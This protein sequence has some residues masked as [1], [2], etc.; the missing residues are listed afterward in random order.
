[1]N[2]VFNPFSGTFGPVAVADS[3]A[4]AAASATAASNSAS[5]ASG[6]ASA[7]NQS[8]IEAVLITQRMPPNANF[9]AVYTLSAGSNTINLGTLALS[10]GIFPDESSPAN[11]MSL[12]IGS[13]SYNLGIL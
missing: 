3:T 13:T 7:A 12:A 2:Y 5:A 8:V 9:S 1:M 11:R 4:Q 10:G 6:S